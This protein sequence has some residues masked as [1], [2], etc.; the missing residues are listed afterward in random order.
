MSFRS[1]VS[2]AVLG[3]L[4]ACAKGGGEPPATMS[5]PGALDWRQMATPD[6]RARLRDWRKAW[7]A[8]LPPAR[9]VADGAA[10][11]RE[12]SALFDPDHGLTGAPPPGRYRCRTFK[13]G[14]KSAGMPGYVA[15][16]WFDCRIDDEG[17]TLSLYKL[18]G[19]QRPVGL[20]LPDAS[21]RLAFLGTLVLGD[22]RQ[23]LQY[24]QDDQRD[25]AGWL[26]RVGD[27]RWRLALPYP[28]FES[29]LDVIELVPAD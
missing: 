16:P 12:Q 4:G 1:F 26:D 3:L 6:D 25:M 24:G 8:A 29:L 10:A 14:T 5:R 22:E 11:I 19:S 15:Y 9:A 27:R 18:T 13:L 28:H 2:I 21:G 20:L 23:P 17:E 7:M